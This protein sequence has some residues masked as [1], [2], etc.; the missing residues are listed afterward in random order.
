M[1]SLPNVEEDEMLRSVVVE[2]CKAASMAATSRVH[3]TTLKWISDPLLAVHASPL[4]DVECRW[5]GRSPA[6]ALCAV[7]VRT[8]LG[9]TI[10]GSEKV[11]GVSA[12][13]EGILVA[14]NQK[15]I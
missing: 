4:V 15:S 7:I 5:L 14:S 12:K 1:R 3:D 13:T 9:N 8:G 2:A 10:N 6:L 11:G